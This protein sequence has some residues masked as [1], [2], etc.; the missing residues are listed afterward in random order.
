VKGLNTNGMWLR[1]GVARLPAG[2]HLVR[3][4]RPSGGLGPGDG[5]KSQLGPVALVRREPE[6]LVALGIRDAQRLCG[7]RW[8]WIEVVSR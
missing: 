2:A 8:D 6:A 5:V 1:A 3:L 4:E 7:K